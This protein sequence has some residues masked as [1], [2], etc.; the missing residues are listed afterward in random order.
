[1]CDQH[2]L[3]RIM[4]A[5]PART[6]DVAGYEAKDDITLSIHS[7]KTGFTTAIVQRNMERRWNLLQTKFSPAHR[8]RQRV[9]TYPRRVPSDRRSAR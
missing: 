4:A 3:L 2:L 7:A 1:M 5:D 6:L 8:Q 9:K